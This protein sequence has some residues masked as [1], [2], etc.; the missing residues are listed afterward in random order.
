MC[1]QTLTEESRLRNPH[2]SMGRSA[3]TEAREVDRARY[4]CKLILPLVG[5]RSVLKEGTQ[6]RVMVRDGDGVIFQLEARAHKVAADVIGI[7]HGDLG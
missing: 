5:P 2:G 7:V 3:E 4:S 1:K 6:G